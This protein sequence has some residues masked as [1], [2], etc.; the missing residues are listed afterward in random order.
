[1]SP[2]VESLPHVLHTLAPLHVSAKRNMHAVTASQQ[3]ASQFAVTACLQN[4]HL[5]DE[6]VVYTLL[7][8][9]WLNQWNVRG[10]RTIKLLLA[11]LKRG[12]SGSLQT[13]PLRWCI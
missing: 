9:V 10:D 3:F 4:S 8:H 1:M 5:S 13:L 2:S 11:S 7:L 6:T 12:V